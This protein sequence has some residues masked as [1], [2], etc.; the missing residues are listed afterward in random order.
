MTTLTTHTTHTGKKKSYSQPGYNARRFF[1]YFEKGKTFV[2]L[3]ISYT[4]LH[5]YLHFR[6]KKKLYMWEKTIGSE[7]LFVFQVYF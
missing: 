6:L 7:N 5:D 4:F 3:T 1:F 2:C